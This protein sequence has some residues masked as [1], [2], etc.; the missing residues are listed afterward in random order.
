M[1]LSIEYAFMVCYVTIPYPKMFETPIENVAG[2]VTLAVSEY[3]QT[4]L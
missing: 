3:N 2:K 4:N 1:S